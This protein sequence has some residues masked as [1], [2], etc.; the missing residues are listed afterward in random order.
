MPCWRRSSRSLAVFGK[1]LWRRRP[2]LRGVLVYLAIS[3]VL[4]GFV[5]FGFFRY[6]AGLEPLMLLVAAPLIARLR[7]LRA[8]RIG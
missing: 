3:V 4:Y 6:L 8:Q 1:A 7:I 5:F 2:I